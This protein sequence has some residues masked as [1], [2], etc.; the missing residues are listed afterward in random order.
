MADKV[1]QINSSIGPQSGTKTPDA[2]KEPNTTVDNSRG[3]SNNAAATT[4]ADLTKELPVVVFDA[5]ATWCGDD[6]MKLTPAQA[7][8]MGEAVGVLAGTA[9]KRTMSIMT[10]VIITIVKVATCWVAIST[11]I[12]KKKEAQK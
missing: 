8:A 5:A 11:K 7:K 6:A 9:D 10:I 3:G 1:R 4:P 12:S 2:A